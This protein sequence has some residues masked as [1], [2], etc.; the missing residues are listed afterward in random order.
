M[1]GTVV[2]KADLNEK[3]IMKAIQEAASPGLTALAAEVA[4]RAKASTAFVDKTGHLRKT[5]RVAKPTKADLDAEGGQEIR[6][7][8]ASAPHAHL[9]E[10]GHAM[11]TKDGQVVGHVPAHPF[12]GPARDS[13]ANEAEA[14]VAH[15]MHKID[16]TVG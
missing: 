10:D 2:I 15:A 7:V 11:V 9:V 16:I 4:A 6:I 3:W 12:L 1:S 8:R 5:I 14:I 13:V